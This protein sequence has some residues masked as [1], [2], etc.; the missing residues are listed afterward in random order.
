MQSKFLNK[1]AEE[2]KGEYTTE[3]SEFLKKSVDVQAEERKYEDTT[4]Q[5]VFSEI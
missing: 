1:P 2:R 5:S 4:M 3:K